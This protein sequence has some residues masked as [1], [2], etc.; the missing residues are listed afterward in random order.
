MEKHQNKIYNTDNIENN[1]CKELFNKKIKESNELKE[2]IHIKLIEDI[3][4]NKKKEE[5]N[6]HNTNYGKP[7]SNEHAL[8][9]SLSTTSAKRSKNPNLTDDKIREIYALKDKILQ[10]DVAEKYNMNREM[11]RRIWNR[12]LIP[13]D[14]PEFLDKKKEEVDLSNTPPNSLYEN[15]NITVEQKTSIGKRS[16]VIDE[17][18]EILQW[19]IKQQ[20]N[21]LLNNK[22]ISSTAISQHLSNSWNKKIS[23]DIIKNIWNGRLLLF[24][25]E[26]TDKEITYKQYLEIIGKNEISNEINK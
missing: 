18:I 10:K 25:F 15:R 8:H 9:I 21:E 2:L 12:L 13:T 26:F 3:E 5:F 6:K 20:N 19:K 11:I 1:I 23:V 16:L 24:E 4:K 22:K 7:L 14:D 17:Y